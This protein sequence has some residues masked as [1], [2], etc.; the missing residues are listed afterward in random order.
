MKLT[1]LFIFWWIRVSLKCEDIAIKTTSKPNPFPF[2]LQYAPDTNIYRAGGGY[3]LWQI[4]DHM[5]VN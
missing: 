5:I 3:V 2:V 1:I 4:I